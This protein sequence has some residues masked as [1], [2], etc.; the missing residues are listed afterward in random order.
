MEY[1]KSCTKKTCRWLLKTVFNIG[2]PIL[3]TLIWVCPNLIFSQT[4]T[5]FKQNS[6]FFLSNQQGNLNITTRK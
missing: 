1:K 3:G 6:N 2:I 5:T 4:E